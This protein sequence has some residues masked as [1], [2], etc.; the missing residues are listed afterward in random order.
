M[1]GVRDAREA[2]AA[3][4]AENGREV[5]GLSADVNRYDGPGPR[6]DGR[7]HRLGRQVEIVPY[8]QQYRPRAQVDDDVGRGAEGEGRKNDL[9]AWAYTQSG[10]RRV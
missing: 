10:E 3:R 9:V 1:G 6:G 4:A 7:F 8:I 5:A 2:P